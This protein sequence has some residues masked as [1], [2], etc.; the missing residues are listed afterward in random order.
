M[1]SLQ[2]FITGGTGFVGA[3]LVAGLNARGVTPRVLHRPTSSQQALAGL[4]YES[5]LGDVLDPAAKLA[6]AMAGC[7]WV[8]HVAAVAD[9]WRQQPDWIYRV[10][11][12]GT[13]NVLLAARLAGVQRVVFTSSL[14][15]LGVPAPGEMLTESSLFNVP[16]Q[17][18]PYGHSKHLAEQA[19]R[20]AV[21]AGISAVIV[22]P[23][24][25]LGPRDV[26]Q[27]SGSIIVEAARGLAK[28][29]LP[30]G[31]N[32]VAVQ[33]VVA[34]H[35]AAAEKGRPGE[36]YILGQANLPHAQAVAT[37][38]EVL[39]KRPPR[40]NLPRWSL[41][42]A[43]LGVRA[44]RF[45]LGNRVPFD[46]NQVRMLGVFIYADT[47]KAVQQLDLPQTPFRQT[48]MEAAD[49]YRRHGFI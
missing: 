45:V 13:Q 25:V 26:N 31:T 14:A 24:I 16:S 10:N 44:A 4:A 12:D 43:A 22:N 28:I 32:Y 29:N 33:D 9:Y 21:D 7:D 3:N 23:S 20:K 18:W 17:V 40:L 42:A 38:C 37:I 30:G 8:F 47:T 48:V 35:I 1:M 15:A 27:I 2:V 6:E 34:G 19:V 46:E 11:V 36:R 41:P 5:V 49:W 39:G